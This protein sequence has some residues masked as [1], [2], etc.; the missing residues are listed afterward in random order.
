MAAAIAIA[1]A[2]ASLTLGSHWLRAWRTRAALHAAAVRDVQ[3]A[4]WDAVWSPFGDA[5]GSRRFDAADG[6]GQRNGALRTV[7]IFIDILRRTRDALDKECTVLRDRPPAEPP[8]NA[9]FIT[10]ASPAVHERLREILKVEAEQASGLATSADFLQVMREH[11]AKMREQWNIAEKAQEQD[12]LVDPPPSRQIKDA[13]NSFARKHIAFVLQTTD[14]KRELDAPQALLAAIPGAARV[15]VEELW[16]RSKPLMRLHREESEAPLAPEE[17]CVFLSDDDPAL[18]ELQ[19]EATT[20]L[21][22]TWSPSGDPFSL[23]L[24]RVAHSFDPA[25]LDRFGDFNTSPPLA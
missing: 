17:S 9:V 5:L 11:Q 21:R 14:L 3:D 22:A 2:W 13:V 8:S 12:E 10:A 15:Q 4:M 6:R 19:M 23:S 24:V 20:A 25:G 7:A 18:A 16:N 1:G